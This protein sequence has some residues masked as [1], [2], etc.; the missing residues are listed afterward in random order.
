MYL[1]TNTFV[2]EQKLCDYKF[3][4]NMSQLKFCDIYMCVHIYVSYIYETKFKN[5]F[6]TTGA[7]TSISS[8]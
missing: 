2:T 5:H 3:F 8:C 4:L 1:V 7:Y 6:I